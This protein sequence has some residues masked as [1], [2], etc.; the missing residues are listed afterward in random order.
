M[1]AAVWFERRFEFSLPVELL[2]NVC[3][4]LRG[5]PT[6]LEEAVRIELSPQSRT[7]SGRLRNT[8][9]IWLTSNR[10]GWPAWRTT[11]PLPLNSLR[12]T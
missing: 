12:R 3:A 11:R 9:A 7:G 10:S 6:R 2:P 1:S 8:P 4:R 5:A